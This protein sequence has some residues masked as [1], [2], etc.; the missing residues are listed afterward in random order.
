MGL[1]DVYSPDGHR[2]SSQE[3]LTAGHSLT[4]SNRWRCARRCHTT[5]YEAAAAARRVYIATADTETMSSAASTLG[6]RLRRWSNVD[7]ALDVRQL[8]GDSDRCMTGP[9]SPAPTPYRLRHHPAQ[10]ALLASI[11]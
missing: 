2:S 5:L 6:Q 8:F 9:P 1:Y 7:A 3:P 10:P 11:G 4:H